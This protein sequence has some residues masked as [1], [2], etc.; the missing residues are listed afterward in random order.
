MRAITINNYG[1]AENLELTELP[2][3]ERRPGQVLVKTLA[4]GVNFIDTYQRAGIAN[5]QKPLPLTLGLEGAGE[6]IE[7]DNKQLTPGDVVAW[8]FA[9]ASYAEYVTI[10]ETK[11]VKVPENISPEIA[12]ASMLQG[13]TAHYLVNDTFKI[14]ENTAALV[15]AGAGGV[16]LLLIQ[17]IKQLGGQVIATASADEKRQLAIQHGA[18]HAIDYKDF[19][20]QI[21][22]LTD[23][24][25]VD[26]VYDGIGQATYMQSLAS[27]KK[28]GLLALF[29]ASSG[30]VPLFD[31]QML[32]SMGSLFITRPTLADYISTKT[33]LQS[34]ADDV[35]KAITNGM[36]VNIHK[37][38]D[39]ADASA[40]HKDI[41]SRETSGKLILKPA[42]DSQ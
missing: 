20:K 39:L 8:P 1:G 32:N 16:G 10:D 29:G 9:P 23:D 15:H 22:E 3:P 28:R 40:A 24:L 27:L 34:R 7:S 17:M 38:Y 2:M 37:T 11:V 5:Y 14:T 26:V 12:A 18:D 25:G 21:N 19:D 13:M 42:S 35:F 36:K 41:E 6:V 4:A 31:L 30:P 33:E